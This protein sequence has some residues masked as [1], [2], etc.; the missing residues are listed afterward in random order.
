MDIE[1]LKKLP[2]RLFSPRN[3]YDFLFNQIPWMSNVES[4]WRL[5][6]A[7]LLDI[8]ILIFLHCRHWWLLNE[9]LIQ[10]FYGGS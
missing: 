5:S 10:K 9:I 6:G 2:F 1:R 3:V 7:T 4:G 8:L